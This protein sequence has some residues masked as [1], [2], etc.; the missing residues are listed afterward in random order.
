MPPAWADAVRRAG[1]RLGAE[2]SLAEGLGHYVDWLRG[3][4]TVSAQ[5]NR[6]AGGVGALNVIGPLSTVPVASCRPP[7]VRCHAQLLEV[8]VPRRGVGPG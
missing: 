6:S 3:S 7:I 2:V 1:P 8:A 5:E 4:A